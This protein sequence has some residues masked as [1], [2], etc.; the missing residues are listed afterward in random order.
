MQAN[1]DWPNRVIT[2]KSGTKYFIRP[3]T[4]SSARYIEFEIRSM[5][6]AFKTN[7]EGILQTLDSVEHH[8]LKGELNAIGNAHNALSILQG[9]KT[10]LRRHA[11]FRRTESIEFCALFCVEDSED[12]A[13]FSEDIIIK[14]WNDW[15]EIPDEDF[16]LLS[17]NVKILLSK[18]YR[19][20]IKKEKEALEAK[21]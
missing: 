1:I 15:K 18:R 21:K 7:L 20:I 9:F 8:L 2:G 11:E 17:V 3:E 13:S 12:L 19:D 16:F 6:Q 4:L 5:T 10:G 14:K